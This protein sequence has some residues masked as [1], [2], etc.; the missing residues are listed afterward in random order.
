MENEVVKIIPFNPALIRILP[1][2]AIWGPYRIKE[3][4]L[5]GGA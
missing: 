2:S 1:E 4:E 5:K 3:R